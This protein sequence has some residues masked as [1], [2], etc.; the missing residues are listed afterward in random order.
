MVTMKGRGLSKSE[1]FPSINLKKNLKE[2]V[3]SVHFVHL[4]LDLWTLTPIRMA[5]I[6]KTGNT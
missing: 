1:P 6:K 2:L 4:K 3:P 5:I